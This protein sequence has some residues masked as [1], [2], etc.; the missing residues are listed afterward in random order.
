MLVVGIGAVDFGPRRTTLVSTNMLPSGW[1][2]FLT[3]RITRWRPPYCRFFASA[4]RSINEEFLDR[5]LCIR[6]RTS[7]RSF[8]RWAGSN[9]AQW[10]VKAVNCSS[11]DWRMSVGN[12]KTDSAL[13]G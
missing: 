4:K 3:S 12:D 9:C 11:V 13:N 6:L 5:C 10:E 7:A 1:R 2:V 8:L